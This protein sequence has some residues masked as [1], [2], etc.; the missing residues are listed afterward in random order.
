MTE[1][2]I[3]P[4][5]PIQEAERQWRSHGWNEA[6]TGMA[7]VTSIMRVQQVLLARADGVL[8]PFGISFARY[9]VL[10]L[11]TFSRRASL[12]L[13]KIGERLQVHRASV[14]NAID[15]LEA[16]GLVRREP[17]PEDGRSTLALITLR[18]RQL[19][20]AATGALN[21]EVFKSM[22]L[23]DEVLQELFGL[24]K[25]VRRNA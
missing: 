6:A 22:G 13:S 23:P 2:P 16:Q 17:N 24:L 21:D 3:L 10:M 9:E 4:F 11:L 18:G 19:A 7:T 15:R 25:D 1:G 12:P 8:K 20:E 5:D 14:T